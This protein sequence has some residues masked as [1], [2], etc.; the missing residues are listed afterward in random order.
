MIVQCGRFI[1][2]GQITEEWFNDD[3][4]SANDF[5]SAHIDF[6]QTVEITKVFA[7]SDFKVYQIIAKDTEKNVL[8]ILTWDFARDIEVSMLQVPCDGGLR[9]ENYIVR[10][11]NQ[12]MNYFINKHQIFDL[13]FN[14]PM[15]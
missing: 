14:I 15:Q 4:E 1:K 7:T 10:G 11:M 9:P 6:D 8:I 3:I 2:Y 5:K 13:E 12:K